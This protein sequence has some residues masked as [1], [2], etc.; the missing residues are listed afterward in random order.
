M[1][2]RLVVLG[3]IGFAGYKYLEKQGA[4]PK[5]PTSTV[6]EIRLAGGPLSSQASLQH[7]PDEPPANEAE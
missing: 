3:A 2:V 4:F 7:N 5:A 6:P 1:L